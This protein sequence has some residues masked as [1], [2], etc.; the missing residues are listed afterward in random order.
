MFRTQPRQSHRLDLVQVLLVV[1][2]D[3]AIRAFGHG[4]TAVFQSITIFPF[5]EGE[6]VSQL[7]NHLAVDFGSFITASKHVINM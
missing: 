4:G 1:E 6:R 2:L 7:F 5:S 3:R